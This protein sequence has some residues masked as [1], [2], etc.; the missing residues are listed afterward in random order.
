MWEV[1]YPN[2]I[3]FYCSPL[4]IFEY[5]IVCSMSLNLLH[6]FMNVKLSVLYSHFTLNS[7]NLDPVEFTKLLL[8][9]SLRFRSWCVLLVLLLTKTNTVYGA[10]I[11]GNPPNSGVEYVKHGS[12]L[13][14]NLVIHFFFTNFLSNFILSSD[15]FHNLLAQEWF[16]SNEQINHPWHTY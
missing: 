15:I 11:G 12:T 5:F 14:W 3:I 9:I 10:I 13:A 6:N 4:D 7:L 2:H 1:F 8:E 16:I